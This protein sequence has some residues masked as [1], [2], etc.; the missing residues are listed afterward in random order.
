MEDKNKQTLTA[1]HGA[2]A[3]YQMPAIARELIASGQLLVLCGVTASG[4]NTISNYLVS[5]GK[6]EHVISH[7][8]RK[9]R[10]NHG[11]IEQN[12]KEYWFVSPEEMLRLV[13]E[14][15]FIEVKAIHGDSCYGTSI[16]SV[17][18]VIRAGYHP[19]MEID[20]QGVLELTE[21]VPGLRPL[22]ILPPSFEVWMER[23]GTRG[24]I[25]DGEKE[26]R[27]R[28]ASMEI[29][30]ALD[31]SAFIL[32]VNHEVEITAAEIIRGV[33]TSS[34]TNEEHRKLAEGLLETIRNI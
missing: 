13:N 1:L 4:K 3:T 17:D 27:L 30:T 20:V 8:T 21:A 16:E 12:G 14:H 24:N 5:H 29:Q 7:T 33:D 26:R 22:F 34:Q 15:K 10:E 28:S 25:S 9:P 19:V 6:Y 32:T 23:L 2:V 11:I 18:S 31:H